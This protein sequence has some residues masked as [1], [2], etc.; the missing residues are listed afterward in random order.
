MAFSHLVLKSAGLEFGC[1]T[2]AG[3]FKS[4]AADKDN[5]LAFGTLV[6]LHHR[7]CAC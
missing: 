6:V 7:R 5:M 1:P 3:A 2:Y 4:N